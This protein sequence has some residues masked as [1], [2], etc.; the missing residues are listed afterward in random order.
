MLPVGV[1]RRR[2]GISSACRS[3]IVQLSNPSP[4]SSPRSN[5]VPSADAAP[6][7]QWPPHLFG[8]SEPPPPVPSPVVPDR[9]AQ[10]DPPRIVRIVSRP[11]G[12]G[13]A[14]HRHDLILELHDARSA[15][16][17]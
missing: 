4:H 9:V 10:I 8:T 3:R 12:I 14:L 2:S 16:V 11:G 17:V 1:I 15:P 6:F 13:R 7:G 5:P